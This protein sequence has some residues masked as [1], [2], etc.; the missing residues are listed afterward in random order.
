MRVIRS[1]PGGGLTPPSARRVGRR[2]G[3][4]RGQEQSKAGGDG[5]LFH[6]QRGFSDKGD[7]RRMLDVRCEGV[8]TPPKSL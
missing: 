6:E 7:S 2:G 5:E 1:E 3:Q 4:G 8:G